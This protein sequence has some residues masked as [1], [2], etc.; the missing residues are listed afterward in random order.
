MYY[1]SLVCARIAIPS[2]LTLT[3]ARLPYSI[4]I[5]MHYGKKVPIN[6][7]TQ[8]NLEKFTWSSLKSEYSKVLLR[9]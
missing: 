1:S 6:L 4:V 8:T 7:Y 2:V 9:V 5:I 3:G